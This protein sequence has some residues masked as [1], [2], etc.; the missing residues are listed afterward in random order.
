MNVYLIEDDGGGVTVVRRRHQEHG[1]RGR[2]GRQRA[3]R[4]QPRRARPRPCRPS[5][6][7]ARRSARPVLCHP[8]E[9]A[10]A[11]GDGGRALL[12]LSTLR[13]ARAARLPA[14]ARPTGTAGRCTIAGTVE[15]GEDVSGFRV[16]ARP[17]PRAGPDRALPRARRGRADERRLLR[18]RS[19]DRP[20]TARRGCRTPRST[21]TPSRRARRSASSRRWRP[22]PRGPGH[23][24]PL[25]G[26]VAAQLE[27]AAA[28]PDGQAQPPPR[29][30]QD[31][32]AAPESEYRG[33]AGDVLVLR[34][35]MTPA[36]RREYAA[37]A[38]RL[39]AVARGRLAARGRVPVR[40]PRRALGDRRDRADHEARRSCS[41]ASAS[42]RGRAPLDP[43]RPARAPRRALPR[44]GRAVIDAGAFA[45]LLCGYCLDAQPGQQVVV[46]S[47]T[48]AAPLLLAVQREL[49]ERGAWPLLRTALPGQ[50]EAWWARGAAT[51][52]WTRS[53]PPSWPRPRAPTPRSPSRRRR[54]RPRWPASTPRAW[55]A[56]RGPARRSARPRCG[57]AGA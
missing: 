44:A 2:G 3:R 57:A 11:E 56:R 27:Q 9:R 19:P 5:R 20:A 15:E 52:T 13:A 38:G 14:P 42:P 30:R 22:A 33:P 1:R 7:R 28:R 47:T 53:P 34:G 29:C 18:A 50:D 26:D 48:L 16:V 24:E 37:V 54:T 51:R 4:D 31:A 39:A 49:L 21:W 6:H 46:R 43:R 40:A 8:D 25:T 36:T 10:D 55:P 35:A 45:R 32:L 23:A 17:R 12:R 41:A